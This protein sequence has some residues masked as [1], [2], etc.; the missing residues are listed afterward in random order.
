MFYNG[1]KRCDAKYGPMDQSKPALQPAILVPGRTQHFVASNDP[2][3][4][5]RLVRNWLHK[6]GIDFKT[7]A[8]SLEITVFYWNVRIFLLQKY[9]N[10]KILYPPQ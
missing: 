5:I 1:G 3:E 2:F 4:I 7:C 6:F 10:K 9:Y 8:E